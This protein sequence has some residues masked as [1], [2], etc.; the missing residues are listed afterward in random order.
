MSLFY[1]LAANEG[2]V[3]RVIAG[4][5]I[6]GIAGIETDIAAAPLYIYTLMSSWPAV[7]I[8][9]IVVALQLAPY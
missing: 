4:I 9:V 3:L 8:L 1:G 5:T 2:V 6:N 7:N